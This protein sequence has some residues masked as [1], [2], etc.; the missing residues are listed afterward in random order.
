MEKN[1]T[2]E[3]Y[4]SDEIARKLVHHLEAHAGEYELQDATL[5][6]N[7]PLFREID[8]ELRYPSFM[9]ISKL[10]GV[11]LFQCDNGT[12][13]SLSEDKLIELEEYIS[14]IHSLTFSRLIK[15]KKIKKGRTN[16]NINLTTALYIP[17][18]NKPI[19]E[20]EDIE[21]ELI[22]NNSQFNDFFENLKG[23]TIND[24][25]IEI[26][27]SVLEGSKGIIKPKERE[28]EGGIVDSKA[29]ILEELEKEIA[30]FDKRQ[31]YAALSH[32]KGP[33]RIRGLAGSG[34]TIILAMKAALIHLKYPDKKFYILFIRKACMT[35]LNY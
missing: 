22:T 17:N 30:K 34:K 11:I 18:Y 19:E 7:Y 35:M 5:Y 27:L 2:T 14:H 1:I 4:Y 10:H 20:C 21:S 6:Y 12:E 28:L 26:I 29:S 23:N 15:E 25:K 24:E 33:Q 16:L 3:D 31:K 13:R 8:D 9:L 32:L